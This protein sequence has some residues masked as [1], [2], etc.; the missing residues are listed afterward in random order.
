MEPPY[1]DED[2]A[3]V[4]HAANAALQGIQDDPSPSSF[5]LENESAEMQASVAEGVRYA[6]RGATPREHHERWVQFKTAHGW[7]YGPDK[8][9]ERK[10]HPCLVPYDFLPPRQQDKNVLFIAIVRALSGR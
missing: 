1:S 4:I 3:K 8:D 5:R 9:D 6:R 7:K 10:T 2:I